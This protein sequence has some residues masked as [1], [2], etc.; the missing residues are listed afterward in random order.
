[1]SKK[2]R[3][4]V[5]KLAR[6]LVYIMGH[7]PYEFGL[8]PDKEGFF[9]YKELLQAIHEESG[10]GYVRQASINEV[11][12]VKDRSLFH[13][14]DKRIKAIEPQWHLDLETPAVSLPKILFT[15]IRTKA[16]PVVMDNGLNSVE[17]SYYPLSPDRSMAE[18]IG[19]RRDHN[20]VILEIRTE[21]ALAERVLFYPFG[22]LFL[23]K[24]ISSRHIAG[25]PVSKD[26]LKA[27]EVQ[28][29]KKKDTESD[30]Q[31]G[32][33]TLEVDRDLDR[34]RTSKGKK[35]KGWK[36]EVRKFRRKK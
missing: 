6:F 19:R 11:L 28:P 35:R 4:R 2:I 27:K 25:P 33:F 22:D 7:S 34:S 5:D 24:E 16:H 1:M 15:G 8:V 36:E 21:T 3:I 12:L 30:F 14:E 18:R 23:V 9:T 32:T 17:G 26:V 31:P 13:S 29:I 20:P 10:W